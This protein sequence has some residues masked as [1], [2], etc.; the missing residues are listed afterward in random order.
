MDA[1]T[2][3]RRMVF[4]LVVAFFVGMATPLPA[5]SASLLRPVSD[6]DSSAAVLKHRLRK[7]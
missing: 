5:P 3:E 6:E 7:S 4:L 1:I 2:W